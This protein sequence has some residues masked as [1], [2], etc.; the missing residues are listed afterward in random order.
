MKVEN[1]AVMLS[2]FYSEMIIKVIDGFVFS[3]VVCRLISVVYIDVVPMN[4]Y[5]SLHFHIL[6]YASIPVQTFNLCWIKHPSDE[7][8]EKK[9]FDLRE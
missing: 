9:V 6:S 7:I 1:T 4:P 3:L 2:R 5:R 8:A